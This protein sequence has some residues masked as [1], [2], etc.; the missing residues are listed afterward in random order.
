LEDIKITWSL[1]NVCEE[2]RREE[3]EGEGRLG[4]GGKVED[5]AEVVV[6]ERGRTE[7]L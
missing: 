3:G 1:E 7:L 5:L 2:W 6:K 4:R